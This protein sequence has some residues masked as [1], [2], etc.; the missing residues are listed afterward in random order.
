MKTFKKYSTGAIIS[1]VCS[2]LIMW[3]VHWVPLLCYTAG[4]QWEGCPLESVGISLFCLQL[5]IWLAH[6]AEKGRERK[7]LWLVHW[8]PL[9]CYTAGPQWEGC[10]LESVGISLFCLQLPIWLVY[11]AEKGKERR[12]PIPLPEPNLV[13]TLA[14][15]QSSTG[16]APC[17]G[18]G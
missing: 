13:P 16:I 11:I 1:D 6:I 7:Y 14:V 15:W 12:Y 4:P 2:V 8:V 3:L 9:L 17:T 18:H 10:P 5:P